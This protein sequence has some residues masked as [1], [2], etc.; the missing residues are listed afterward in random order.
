MGPGSAT[1]TAM[2]SAAPPMG[3]ADAL[4]VYR[5]LSLAPAFANATRARAEQSL[6]T[7]ET[8]AFMPAGPL[9]R[10]RVRSR[11]EQGEQGNSDEVAERGFGPP[12]FSSTVKPGGVDEEDD[13][14]DHDLAEP[15][16]DEER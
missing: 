15:A 7:D 13:G 8:S 4:A 9:V 16:N 6:A 5:G 10:M 1:R 14:R 3:R 12:N 2:P 11:R